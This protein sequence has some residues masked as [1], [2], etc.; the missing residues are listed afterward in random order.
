MLLLRTDRTFTDM[1]INQSIPELLN[2]NAIYLY[3][4]VCQS[5]E[6]QNTASKRLVIF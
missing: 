4:S 1:E 6:K 2:S 5:E 3:C